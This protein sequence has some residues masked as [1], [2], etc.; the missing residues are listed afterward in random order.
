MYTL[1]ICDGIDPVCAQN[2][3]TYVEA[4]QSV[5]ERSSRKIVEHWIP[6]DD[7]GPSHL[8]SGLIDRNHQRFLKE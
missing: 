6:I 3:C 5:I 7:A 4:K 1:C 2:F 8:G